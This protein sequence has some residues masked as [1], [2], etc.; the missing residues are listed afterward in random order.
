M[1]ISGHT[2]Y[3]TPPHLPGHVD[4]V[5]HDVVLVT[6]FPLPPPQLPGHVDEVWH[7]VVLVTPFPPPSPHLPG[8]VDEVGHDVVLVTPVY[9]PET[10][11]QR[12]FRRR[13]LR[14]ALKN[15]TSG[16]VT[17]EKNKR[18]RTPGIRKAGGTHPT[19]MHSCFRVHLHLS[20][21]EKAFDTGRL[22][23]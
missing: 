11:A 12:K 1:P 9:L 20:E 10:R 16:C 21:S 14:Y 8:H 3:P 7:D 17:V 23:M 22:S 18:R 15:V 19:G 5:G 6:P 2:P 4:E 13:V